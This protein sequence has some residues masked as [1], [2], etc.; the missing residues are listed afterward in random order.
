[1]SKLNKIKE[2]KYVLLAAGGLFVVSMFGTLNVYHGKK[3]TG[4]ELVNGDTHGE[5]VSFVGTLVDRNKTKSE[6]GLVLT[7]R[8]EDGYEVTCVVPQDVPMPF[9]EIEDRFQ[10]QA[11]SN[12]SF[13]TV[14]DIKRQKNPMHKRYLRNVTVED[15]YAIFQRGQ[16]IAKLEAPGI[17]DGTYN[18]LIENYNDAGYGYLSRPEED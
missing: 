5:V 15:E 18:N 2:F 14:L 16:W 7:L 12:G 3:V 8:T 13:L 11:S 6:S 9:C 4:H 1:M 17:P 10:V